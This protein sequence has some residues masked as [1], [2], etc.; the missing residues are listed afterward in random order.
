MSIAHPRTRSSG[1]RSLHLLVTAGPTR[2]PIDPVRFISNRSSGTLGYAVA[3][4]GVR[5]GHRVVLLSGPTALEPPRG[6]RLEWFETAAELLRSMRR[7][8]RW[9]DA[10]VMTAAVSDFRPRRVSVTKIGRSG[11]LRLEL[12]ATPDIIGALGRR[13][14]RRVL[15]GCAVESSRAVARAARKLVQKRLDLIMVTTVGRAAVSPFGSGAM[16]ATLV[17]SSGAVEPLGVRPK[18]VLARRL[19]DSVEGL[20]YGRSARPSVRRS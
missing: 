2:E 8:W 1:R 4:E 9:C 13:K 15:V 7:R 10:V 19:L 16:Q 6:A 5:R 11:A 12:V 14:G 20:C 18:R 17:T 3:S